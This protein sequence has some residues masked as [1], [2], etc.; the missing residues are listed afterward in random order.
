MIDKDVDTI[1]R[2]SHYDESTGV[3][4]NQIVQNVQPVLNENARLRA[5]F[6]GMDKFKKAIVCKHLLHTA[7]VPIAFLYKMRNGQCCSDGKKYD[8][9]SSDNEERLRAQ[10][11]MQSYH[12][13]CMIIPGRIISKPQKWDIHLP[14]K[15]QR[16]IDREKKCQSPITPI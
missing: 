9:F 4:T 11:H 15:V 16:E 5:E 12:K 8:M 2:K 6:S 10:L 1:V 14:A 7:K 13:E 3:M